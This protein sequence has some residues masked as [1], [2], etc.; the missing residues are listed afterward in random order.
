MNQKRVIR[1]EALARLLGVSKGTIWRML[2]AGQ[3][4]KSFKLSPAQ[5]VWDAQEIE[6]W[7]EA[8]KATRFAPAAP[9]VATPIQR[10]SNPVKA[11]TR[12]DAKHP[13][14]PRKEAQV[15]A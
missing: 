6:D 14:R 5:T 11:S 3:L 9:T 10:G 1:T 2:A 12:T 8:K 15:A 13:G 4:P 7:L